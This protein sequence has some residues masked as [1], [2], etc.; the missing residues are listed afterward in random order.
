[1]DPA[2]EHI[3]MIRATAKVPILAP[4]G[5]LESIEQYINH[6]NTFH[7]FLNLGNFQFHDPPSRTMEHKGSV[8]RANG[9]KR[10]RMVELSS[11][12]AHP[13]GNFPSI[14]SVGRIPICH[15]QKSP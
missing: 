12:G 9:I 10:S 14:L 8:R 11:L 7:V 13:L 4:K 6:S 15:K 1:P 5:C 3:Q 2:I